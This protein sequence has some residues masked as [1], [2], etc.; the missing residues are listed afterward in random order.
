V[1]RIGVVTAAWRAV[2]HQVRSA[3]VAR[4][5]RLADVA[6][7]IGYAPGTVKNALYSATATPSP[8]LE[9]ALRGWVNGAP[10][11]A[12]PGPAPPSAGDTRPRMC[13][14]SAKILAPPD[15]VSA[16]LTPQWD[17]RVVRLA[18]HDWGLQMEVLAGAGLDCWELVSVSG[19]VAYLKREV[20]GGVE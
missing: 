16:S 1:R 17:Y 3:S 13:A 2:Q 19:G 9:A 6:A 11:R 12:T 20:V 4:N 8:A 15:I 14:P 5:M 10:V 18:D 7:A